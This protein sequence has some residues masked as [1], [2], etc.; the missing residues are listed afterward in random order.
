MKDFLSRLDHD[1]IVAAI[2]D[3]ES[4]TSG[5]IRVHVT[6]RKPADLEAAARVRFEKLGMAKT[7]E[8]N[9]VLFYI[10]PGSRQFRILGD[11]GVHEKCGDEFWKEVA[12][13]M[14]EKFRRGHFTDGLVEGIA[15][16]GEVLARHFPRGA[17][18]KNELPDEVT[19]D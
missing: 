18:D 10:C 19:Q 8:R 11:A 3:A 5:E 16:I 12:A 1:R 6:R 4:K 17:A 14:E 9:G 13:A 7:A 15:K 2:R